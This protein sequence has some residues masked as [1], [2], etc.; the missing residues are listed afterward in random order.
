MLSLI[1]IAMDRVCL[2]CNRSLTKTDPKKLEFLQEFNIG[3]R[4][5]GYKARHQPEEGLVSREEI[6]HTYDNLSEHPAG[7]ITTRIITCG[8]VL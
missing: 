3:R 2:H 7:E 1:R 5:K 8:T 6:S 4:Q